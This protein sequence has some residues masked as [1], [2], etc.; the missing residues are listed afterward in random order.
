[1]EMVLKNGFKKSYINSSIYNKL[2]SEYGEE[3]KPLYYSQLKKF[4]SPLIV[5]GG[6]SK[7]IILKGNVGVSGNRQKTHTQ[8]KNMFC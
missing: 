1:M 6:K 2:D 4:V 3:K 7:L 5:D 8:F